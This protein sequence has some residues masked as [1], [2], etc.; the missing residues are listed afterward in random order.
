MLRMLLE[1]KEVDWHEQPLFFR[2]GSY[3][4]KEEYS[5]P[6]V[7]PITQQQVFARRTR[8]VERAFEL[9]AEEAC[10][11][12]LSRFWEPS[13]QAGSTEAGAHS[14]SPAE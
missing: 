3:V 14:Q 12:L 5:K 10:G 6:A 2:Y 13:E 4:K 1:E 7:N 11:F 9:P 8:S